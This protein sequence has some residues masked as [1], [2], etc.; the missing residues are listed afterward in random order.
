MLSSQARLTRVEINF[1][2]VDEIFE[3]ENP[4]GLGG[5]RREE[6]RKATRSGRSRE[7]CDQP[8]AGGQR[9]KTFPCIPKFEND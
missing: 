3:W 4:G 5:G 2:K 6:R 9:G 7:R 8:V 1:Q